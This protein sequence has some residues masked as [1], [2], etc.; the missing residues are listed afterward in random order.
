MWIALARGGPEENP[1]VLRAFGP[2]ATEAEATYWLD[3]KVGPLDKMDVI[4][5]AY[6]KPQVL[7]IESPEEY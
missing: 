4:I 3:Q 1:H 2:Y 7:R 5:R 6:I